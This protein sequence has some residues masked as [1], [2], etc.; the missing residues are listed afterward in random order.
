M[1]GGGLLGYIHGEVVMGCFRVHGAFAGGAIMQYMGF[2]NRFYKSCHF[3]VT[4]FRNILTASYN[5]AEF[6]CCVLYFF[7]G[8]RV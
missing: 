7:V 8:G 2:P 6:I 1:T 5:Y 4:K 3:Q